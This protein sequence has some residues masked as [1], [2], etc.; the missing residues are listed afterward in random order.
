MGGAVTVQPT[1]EPG[2][3]DRQSKL[4]LAWLKDG[5]VIVPPGMGR[6][7]CLQAPS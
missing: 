3:P 6:R 1:G 5:R 2:E 4:D 7:M